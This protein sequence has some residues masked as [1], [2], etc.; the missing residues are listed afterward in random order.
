LDW[1]DQ[2][3][4]EA[5]VARVVD[6]TTKGILDAAVEGELSEPESP[7]LSPLLR[8]LTAAPSEPESPP[9]HPSVVGQDPPPRRR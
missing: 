2:M 1:L 9:L 7:P 8:T 6:F 5:S 3:D 4:G